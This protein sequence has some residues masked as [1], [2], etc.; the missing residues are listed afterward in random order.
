MYVPFSTKA[1]QGTRIE[2]TR[3]R[4]KSDHATSRHIIS[5]Q[6]YSSPE[7]P[8]FFHPSFEFPPIRHTTRSSGRSIL[9]RSVRSLTRFENPFSENI[10]YFVR[11][12]PLEDRVGA[13]PKQLAE[14]CHSGPTLRC[15]LRCANQ[16][17]TILTSAVPGLDFVTTVPLPPSM[18]RSRPV[19]FAS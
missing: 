14:T 4:P 19:A 17:R 7:S 11:I 1:L 3:V 18:A 8:V 10:I 9:F 5:V 13:C 16:L 15:D 12:V 6:P 2:L